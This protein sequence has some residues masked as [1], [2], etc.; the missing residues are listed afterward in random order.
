MRDGKNEEEFDK[1]RRNLIKLKCFIKI[2]M[3]NIDRPFNEM[4]WG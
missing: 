3:M 2:S 4:R 1:K